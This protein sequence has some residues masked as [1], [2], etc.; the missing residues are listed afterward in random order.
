MGGL[1]EWVENVWE[2]TW[3]A[4]A[5]GEWDEFGEFVDDTIEDIVGVFGIEGETIT[6]IEL[7]N[8]SV[9]SEPIKNPIQGIVFQHALNDVSI[10]KAFRRW[11]ITG[12]INSLRAYREYGENTYTHGL[13]TS[14]ILY[15]STKKNAVEVVLGTIEGEPVT[16]SFVRVATPTIIPWT[17]W[18]LLQNHTFDYHTGVITITGVNWDYVST[19]INGGTGNY[20]ANFVNTVVTTTTITSEIN[21]TTVGGTETTT[22][23]E[24]TVVSVDDGTNPPDETITYGTPVVTV[25]PGDGSND[26]DYSI[27]LVNDVVNDPQTYSV[28]GIVPPTSEFYYTVI[29]SL[30]SAPTI[31]KLWLY[32]RSLGTYPTLDGPVQA[33]VD[34]SEMLPIVP[35]KKNGVNLNTDTGTPEYQ[36]S[37]TLLS[38][39]GLNI[40]SLIETIE[41]NPDSDLISDAF[42]L[43]AINL[44]TDTVEGKRV[45]FALFHNMFTNQ[46]VDSAEY[47]SSDFPKPSNFYK[48]AEQNYNTLLKYNYISKTIDQVGSI[49]PVGEVV[50]SFDIQP[51]TPIVEDE[52]TGEQ[53]GGEI[54]SSITLQ[55]QELEGIYHEVTVHGLVM[56]TT[57]ISTE[58]SE[59][60]VRTVVLSNDPDEVDL[61]NI[62]MSGSLIDFFSPRE[63]EKL[64]HE[65]MMLGLYAQD[66]KWLDWY[67]SADFLGLLDAG[68]KVFAIVSLVLSAGTASSFSS[69]LWTLGQ[70]LIIQAVIDAALEDLLE[71]AGDD[72]GDRNIALIA[73]TAATVWNWGGN[74]FLEL[75]FAEQFLA[76]VSAISQT[77]SIDLADQFTT[78]ETEFDELSTAYEDQMEELEDIQ[79]GLGIHADSDIEAYDIVSTVTHDPYETPAD[80]Y[81]RTIHTG[82]PGVLTLSQIE[83]YVDTALRLP[84]FKPGITH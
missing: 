77:A 58:T 45:L 35:L 75:E 48:I 40:D 83:S 46:Q 41:S 44:Y 5:H 7:A 3:D 36:T 54:I 10:A 67:E 78:L 20:E 13:P 24:K 17:K 80:F 52:D 23:T 63:Q 31:K 72:D 43:F 9:Y 2:N 34:L 53:T 55:Y 64:I 4:V 50:T 76:S 51:N 82:N 73:H 70:Q 11:Y 19:T 37:N 47:N 1:F 74:N 32:Q 69:F 56:F 6:A 38:K 71:D 42:I 66:S 84:E 28:T 65:T 8:S 39:I 18:Y 30:D 60:K 21:I 57:I 16:T 26:G 15:S 33:G 59:A 25:Q 14:S 68:L 29:Y 81:Q 22:T 27:G 62:P 12:T 79:S 61:F 49:C